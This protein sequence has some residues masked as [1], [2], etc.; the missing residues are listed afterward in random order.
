[1]VTIPEDLDQLTADWLTGALRQCDA[2]TGIRVVSF[3]SEILGD[4]GITGQV[5]RLK[6]VT[7]PKDG[8]AP[9][10]I[11]IKLSS[12]DPSKKTIVHAMRMYEREVYFYKQIAPTIN[13]RIPQCYY[14]DINIETGSHVLLLEDIAP[15]RNGNRFTGCSI[16]EAECAIR[17]IAFFHVSWW[18]KSQLSALAWLDARERSQKP[19]GTAVRNWKPFLEKMGRILPEAAQEAGA[20]LVTKR[21][22][23]HEH[24][25]QP[26][27]TLVHGDFQPDNFFFATPE[28][29]F[30]FAVIDWQQI[31][32]RRGIY[33]VAGL[34]CKN[35]SIDA[36]RAAEQKL[37]HLY[38]IILLENGIQNYDYEQ[39]WYDY[40]ISVIEYFVKLANGIGAGIF[41]HQLKLVGETILTRLSAAILDL[42]V[43]EIIPN[44]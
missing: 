22:L 32:L 34:L 26:P 43:A 29:G 38:H 10:T 16:D 5:A 36:R 40:R 7:E 20:F 28:G 23:V 30:P 24:L 33:D 14:A 2:L 41:D 15:A 11:I 4:R 42:K 9:E 19:Q 3:R 18:E 12:M 6:L 8:N 37:L 25:Q 13:V 44:S 1:M 21:S 17:E 31:S 35:L 27:L 39:L